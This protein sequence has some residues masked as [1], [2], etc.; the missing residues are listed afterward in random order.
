MGAKIILAKDLTNG[1]K[2]GIMTAK[3]WKRPRIFF[4][5]LLGTRSG[6]V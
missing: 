6:G 3:G 4:S 2:F 1:G 5:I